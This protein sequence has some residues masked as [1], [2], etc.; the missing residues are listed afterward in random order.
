MGVAESCSEVPCRARVRH[1]SAI[2]DKGAL[3][4]MGT[5][6]GVANA[7]LV[8]VPVMGAMR[9]VSPPILAARI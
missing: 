5:M 3:T 6:G 7:S 8:C 4:G 1:R 2:A 9:P